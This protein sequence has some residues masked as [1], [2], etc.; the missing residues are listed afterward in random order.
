[1]LRNITTAALILIAAN[2]A[3]RD[4]GVGRSET[5]KRLILPKGWREEVVRTRKAL[6]K[7]YGESRSGIWEC[8]RILQWALDGCEPGMLPDS[9]I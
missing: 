6:G 8:G 7:Y 5:A 2:M 9:G 4:D 1:M 3:A